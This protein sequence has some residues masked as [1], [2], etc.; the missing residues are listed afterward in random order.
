MMKNKYMMLLAVLAL[1][2][3]A[4]NYDEDELVPSQ[5]L[6]SYQL[7]QGNHDYDQTILDFYKNYGVY[8]LYD[9]SDKDAYW[10]VSGW[11]MFDENEKF[12]SAVAGG[13][14]IC[15]PSDQNYVRQQ[16]ALLDEVWFSK[17]TEKGK[18]ALL[19]TKILLCSEVDSCYVTAQYNYIWTPVFS[20]T[21]DYI[22]HKDEV[23]AWYN[24]DHICV[25]WGNSDIT[26]MTAADKH[27]FAAKLF[28]VWP[29]YIAERKAGPSEEF[30]ASIDYANLGNVSNIVN[31]CAAGILSD[32]YN[33]TPESDWRKFIIGM[34]LFS[35]DWLCDETTPAPGQYDGWTNF[36]YASYGSYYIH[37]AADYRGLLSSV[38]DTNGILKRRY[39]I[40]RQYFIDNYGMDLQAIGN[41]N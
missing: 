35:E 3:T 19:P 37:E 30:T 29:E 16:M 5:V 27:A 18:K 34:L 39:Q 41:Q 20:Y 22:V 40:V 23:R 10:Y 25:G 26:Q 8:L 6:T 7:P 24:F 2:F 21:V 17:M 4:C 1:C 38:K 15:K 36:A 9:F 14:Y 31:C 33:C 32:S 13:N 11:R 12:T 28:H